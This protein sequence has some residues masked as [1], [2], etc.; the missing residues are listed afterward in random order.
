MFVKLGTLIVN[1]D[2]ISSFNRNRDGSGSIWF[3]GEPEPSRIDA[4]DAATLAAALL[5]DDVPPPLKT[6]LIVVDI[7][8]DQERTPFLA[9][10]DLDA[11]A[12]G[13]RHAAAVREAYMNDMLR[14]RVFGLKIGDIDQNGL[15]GT[16]S[17]RILFDG[18]PADDDQ[19]KPRSA[20]R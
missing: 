11:I 7:G 5:P 8:D 10:N 18:G 13:E 3:A 15:C 6:Y 2:R 17:G 12:A 9:A 16:E 1:T 20:R 19:P 4:K 14:V